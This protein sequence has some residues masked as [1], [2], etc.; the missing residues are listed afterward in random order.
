MQ[1][2]ATGGSSLRRFTDPDEPL[3]LTNISGD[4]SRN[5]TFPLETDS[6]TDARWAADIL[7]LTQAPLMP[8][9]RLVT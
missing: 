1:A 6:R 8:G 3:P 7:A 5:W 9:G 2:K 4:R